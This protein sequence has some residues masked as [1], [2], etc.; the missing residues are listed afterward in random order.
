MD[1]ENYVETAK[2]TLKQ[3]KMIKTLSCLL[4]H[5]ATPAEEGL[6]HMCNMDQEDPFVKNAE[7]WG[8]FHELN[9]LSFMT[10][11]LVTTKKTK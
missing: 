7:I 3:M 11:Q 2:Q 4:H 6:S 5:K 8:C 10:V 1:F 9:H